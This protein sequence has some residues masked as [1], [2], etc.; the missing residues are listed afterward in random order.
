MRLLLV[1]LHSS[2]NA[3]DHALTLEAVRQLRLHLNEPELVLAMND[4]ASYQEGEETIGSFYTWLIRT[5]PDG[6]RRWRWPIIPLLLLQALVAALVWRLTRRLPTLLLSTGQ[7]RL[8]RAYTESDAVV[9]CAGNFLYSSGRVGF[10]FILSIFTIAYGWLVGKPLY[11]LPQTIGPL[12]REWERAMVRWLVARARLVMV[13]EPRSLALLEAI[14]AEMQR[15]RLV[16]DIAFAYVERDASR[17]EQLLAE[18][19]GPQ[20][21]RTPLLGMT[22]MNWGAQSRHFGGQSSYED[23]ICAVIETFLNQT[24]GHVVLF[25]QVWGPTFIEDDRVP[26]RRVAARSVHT[27]RVHMVD[28]PLTPAVLKSCYARMGLLV[29]TRMH[30]NIFALS[31]GT[32]VVAIGYRTKT[33]GIME[34]L[35]MERWLVD[36]REVG[37]ETFPALVWRA[38]E[39][40]E[41]TRHQLAAT[42]PT[43]QT[44]A[45]QAGCWVAEDWK[46]LEHERSALR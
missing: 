39:A 7:Q 16:P 17:A 27:G 25:A 35:G 38:W 18:V 31:E 33:W 12:E 29:G 28:Q 23:G 32:P 26:A 13:R 1:N 45:G 20:W 37:P 42:M 10:P 41:A 14:G 40:R 6:S 19:V 11:M 8:L 21:A 44:Q 3:G 24:E 15:C 9:S 2:H 30:S 5:M 46:R 22:L 34:M 4:P 43:I 36:I